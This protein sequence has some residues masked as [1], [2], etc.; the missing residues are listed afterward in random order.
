MS[1]RVSYPIKESVLHCYL[2]VSIDVFVCVVHPCERELSIG[3]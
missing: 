2:N 1:V 3:A